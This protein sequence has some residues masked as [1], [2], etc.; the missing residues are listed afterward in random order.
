MQFPDRIHVSRLDHLFLTKSREDF[1]G[2]QRLF[3][4]CAHTARVFIPPSVLAECPFCPLV[5]VRMAG[6][7]PGTEAGACF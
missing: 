6:K 1:P 3:R 7:S 5:H 2:N 4:C